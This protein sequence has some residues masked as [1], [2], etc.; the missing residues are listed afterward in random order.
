M[1]ATHTG[2]RQLIHWT[3]GLV[4][5]STYR[6]RDI[7]PNCI[8]LNTGFGIFIEDAAEAL[9]GKEI[10]GH[11]M[12]IYIA[13]CNGSRSTPLQLLSLLD[14]VTSATVSKIFDR[15]NLGAIL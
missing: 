6:I 1:W 14:E 10:G 11:L 8:V 9:K 13:H 2:L 5:R 4:K 15:L 7:V 12:L 3:A